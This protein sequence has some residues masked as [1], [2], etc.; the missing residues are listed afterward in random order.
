MD[1]FNNDKF[2]SSVLEFTKFKHASPS[3]EGET[4]SKKAKVRKYPSIGD[5]LNTASYGAIFTTPQSDRIYVITRGTW[6]SK[7]KSKVV[8]GFSLDTPY[9]E[10]VGYSKRT[11]G[12]HG[13]GDGS[14]GEEK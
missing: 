8:K 6:G 14:G 9:E 1:L 5:A 12:K 4:E 10:I 2:H 7:S 3:K 11:R 13:A